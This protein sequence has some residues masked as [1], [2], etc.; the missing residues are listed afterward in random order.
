MIVNKNFLEECFKN[1]TPLWYYNLEFSYSTFKCIKLTEP[2]KIFIKHYTLNGAI[3][4]SDEKYFFRRIYYYSN[5]KDEIIIGN[6]FR[7]E[8]E[9]I[10]AY[11]SEINNQI[12]KLQEFY[13]TKLK[14]LK[15]KLV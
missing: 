15:S 3:E 1:N 9:C 10:E 4:L 2:I 5:T 12:D 7:T 8:E 13:E 11:R 6:L 14:Y